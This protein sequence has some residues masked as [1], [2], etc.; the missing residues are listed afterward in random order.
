MEKINKIDNILGVKVN[1]LSVNE[2]H[3]CIANLIENNEKTIIANVNVHALNLAFRQSWLRDFFNTA[4]IV[5]CDGFGVKLG[6]KLLGHH[7]PERITYADWMWQI[8]SFASKR[9]FSF[10][11]LGA[12]KGIAENAASCLAERF[13]NIRILGSHHGYFNKEPESTENKCVINNINQTKPDILVL[14][15]GMPLQER[16]LSENWGKVNANIALTGGAV[17]D[18]ISGELKRGPKFLIDNGFEWLARLVIEPKRLWRRYVL[19]NPLFLSR[20]V[21][22]KIGLLKF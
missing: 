9:G 18:Y 2:L 6:A 17:F 13:P 10:Y 5:F 1:P 4:P 11:F 21:L 7:I 14:G 22:Q 19:G 16:W 3:A 20:V 12:R 8:A 15:F